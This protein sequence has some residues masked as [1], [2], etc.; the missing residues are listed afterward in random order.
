MILGLFVAFAL[1]G[2]RARYITYQPNSTNDV[3]KVLNKN[4]QGTIIF[5]PLLLPMF[6]QPNYFGEGVPNITFDGIVGHGVYTLGGRITL[7]TKISNSSAGFEGD[8]FKIKPKTTTQLIKIEPETRLTVKGYDLSSGALFVEA[9]DEKVNCILAFLPGADGKFYL[10][11]QRTDDGGL[12][13]SYENGMV[14]YAD[15]ASCTV[16]LGFNS[17]QESD[18]DFQERTEPGTK[19]DNGGSFNGSTG[20]PNFGGNNNSNNSNSNNGVFKNN[21][22]TGTGNTGTGINLPD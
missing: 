17:S 13:L 15:P 11:G 3:V 4:K 5:S 19:T 8:V 21:S 1:E 14:F 10:A 18:S 7:T 2:C 9:N 20:M 22:S 12:S 6:T 16:H